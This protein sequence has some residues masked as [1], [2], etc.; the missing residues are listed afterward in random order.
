MFSPLILSAV[1][2]IPTS[3]LVPAPASRQDPAI[4]VWLNDDGRYQRSDPVKVQVRARNDG[5]LLVLHVDPDGRLR[6]L[7]PLGPEDDT[8]IQGGKKYEIV[9]R[10]GRE[11]FVISAR[12]GH[13]T[14]Y[15]AVSHDRFQFD[16]YV[17]DDRWDF[18]A[19]DDVRISAKPEDD[20]NA[21]V[22]GLAR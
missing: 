7:F 21:F 11:A 14:V 3:A 1:L 20:L 8:F 19:L 9:D 15:A 4:R 22:R 12:L 13:G 5:H 17:R 16:R 10:G 6:V 18:G 2:G